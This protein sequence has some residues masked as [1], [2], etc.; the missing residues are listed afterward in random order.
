MLVITS[1]WKGANSITCPKTHSSEV[2]L[3]SYAGRQAGRQD[4]RHAGRHAG[5]HTGRHAGTQ[6]GS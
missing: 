3:D 2:F 4:G 5:R 6:A 1:S